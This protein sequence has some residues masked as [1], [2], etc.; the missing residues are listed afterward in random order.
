MMLKRETVILSHIED[1]FIVKHTIKQHFVAEV[2]CIHSRGTNQRE[3]TTSFKR[4][5]RI[6]ME[7]LARFGDYQ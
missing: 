3:N 4:Y 1:L 6:K 7:F 5:P 2:V